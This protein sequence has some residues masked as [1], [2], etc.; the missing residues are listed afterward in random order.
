MTSTN[1]L[2]ARALS[3]PRKTV[4]RA[5][6]SLR[7][8]PFLMPLFVAMRSRSV[9][10]QEIAGIIAQKQQYTQRPLSDLAA[11]NALNW[12]IQVGVLRREV[13][14]QGI[15][16]SFRLTPLGHHIIE[17]WQNQGHVLPPATWPDRF[18]NALNR[19]FRL[20]F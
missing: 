14:G 8:S 2:G 1:D 7:V 9:D 10:I 17:Q 15:T 19:W 16:N 13:D 11:E 18:D 5:E 4:E 6:R 3:Y 20:L 12:L